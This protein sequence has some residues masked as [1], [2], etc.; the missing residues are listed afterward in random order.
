M[1][2]SRACNPETGRCVIPSHLGRYERAYE[3]LDDMRIADPETG[4]VYTKQLEHDG[5]AWFSDVDEC[6][7]DSS[8]VKCLV[9]DDGSLEWICDN[10]HAYNNLFSELEDVRQGAFEADYVS[11]EALRYMEETVR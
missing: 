8:T 1:K 11:P 5:Q 6:D 4:R 10:V 3:A 9:N 7:E 2:T